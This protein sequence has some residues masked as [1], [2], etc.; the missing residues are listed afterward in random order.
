MGE[1][2]QGRSSGRASRLKPWRTEARIERLQDVGRDEATVAGIAGTGEDLGGNPPRV[3]RAGASHA[4]DKGPRSRPSV[5]LCAAATAPKHEMR[6]RA[7]GG[8]LRPERALSTTPHRSRRPAA[9]GGRWAA[10]GCKV[11]V[12]NLSPNFRPSRHTTSQ[13]LSIVSAAEIKRSRSGRDVLAFTSTTASDPARLQ[14]TQPQRSR[15]SPKYSCPVLRADL[16][17]ALFASLS[18]AHPLIGQDLNICGCAQYAF[19]AYICHYP[20]ARID[21]AGAI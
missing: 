8:L 4:C 16:P 3:L 18:M 6:M 1:A 9:P 21:L 14:T 2:L 13:L 11:Q 15:R 20:A 12:A 7:G 19:S 17:G 10:G 5:W